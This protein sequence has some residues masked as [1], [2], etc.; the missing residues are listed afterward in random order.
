MLRNGDADRLDCL[1][2]VVPFFPFFPLFLRLGV[3]RLEIVTAMQGGEGCLMRFDIVLM[4][5]LPS[6]TTHSRVQFS[7]CACLH[8]TARLFP[9]QP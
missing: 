7:L 2:S 4:V 8:N 3:H 5:Y 1:L 9:T 6:L